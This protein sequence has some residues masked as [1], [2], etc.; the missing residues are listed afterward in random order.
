[1]FLRSDFSELAESFRSQNVPLPYTVLLL[2]GFS[3][4]QRAECQLA[5]L[6]SMTEERK[7]YYGT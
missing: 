5:P 4:R 6:L 7:D 1:M 2:T 3:P